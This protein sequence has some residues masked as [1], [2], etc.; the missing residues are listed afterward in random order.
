[1]FLRAGGYVALAL[2]LNGLVFGLGWNA[3]GVTRQVS[4]PWFA[5]PGWAIG[6]VWTL[7]LAGM[8]AAD[9]LLS[10]RL[11]GAARARLLG[12]VLALD[13]LAYPFFTR[14]RPIV[15]G[16]GSRGMWVRQYWRPLRLPARIRRIGA[17]HS[18]SPWWRFG[19]LMR[20]RLSSSG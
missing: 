3:T 17:P 15:F 18:P 9:A 14:W 12:R 4:Q 11:P 19:R 10:A 13:C 8:G 20:P 5:P 2:V 1:M 16:R 6:L 7:L